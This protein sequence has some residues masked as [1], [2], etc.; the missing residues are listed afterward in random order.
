VGEA[1]WIEVSLTVNGELAEAVAEVL[2]RYA[3]NGVV[4]ESGVAFKDDEDEGTAAGPIRVFAYLPVDE[5]LEEKQSHLQEA[6][7]HLGQIQPLP[8]A[9]FR[10]IED[11]DWMAAWKK[12]YQPIPIGKRLLILPAWIPQSDHSRV[13]VKIDPSMAFGTGTHPST[14]LC[15]ELIESRLQPGED[16]IDVGCGSGI[17]S[18]AAL[19]LGAR[20]ALGVDIDSAS[21]RSTRENSASNGVT[22]A[23]EVGLGSVAEILAGQFS[24]RRAPFVLANILA[25]VIIRLFAAGL[26]DLVAPGGKIVLAGI[27]DEQAAGVRQA[28][29][30]HGLHFSDM[31]SQ[32]DWVA[33]LL[34]K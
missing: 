23:M 20:H 19:K 5:Y 11:E 1:R 24:L 18:I 28:A 33:L 22:S 9:A 6:L 17:L 29:E 30:E 8:E 12:H 15:L 10:A 4:C 14:Q 7:W 26:A 3:S 21:I 32:G 27:L 31:R 2:D 13:A 16:V 34:S 25:P